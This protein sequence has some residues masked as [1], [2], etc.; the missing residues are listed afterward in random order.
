MPLLVPGHD[1]SKREPREFGM[2]SFTDRSPL[3]AEKH[4]DKFGKFGIVV[5]QQWARTDKQV[6]GFQDIKGAW[7]AQRAIYLPEEGAVLD[8]LRWL[9]TTAHD[10]VKDT[11]CYR[12]NDCAQLTPTNAITNK[13]MAGIESQLLS[14]N[15]L[16]LYEY[17][18][19]EKNARQSQWRIVQP[20]PLY[21]SKAKIL[22]GI[23]HPENWAKHINFLRPPDE[24][25]T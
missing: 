21:V 1:F 10:S 14:S 2:I 19:P 24:A 3:A 5:S 16:T 4:R 6:C 12:D 25:I 11:G 17:L 20:L 7:G 9:Y 8:A 22:G 23:S 18:E 15:L 13:A